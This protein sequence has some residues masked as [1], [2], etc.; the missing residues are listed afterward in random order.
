MQIPKKLLPSDGRFGS[1]PSKVPHEAMEALASSSVIGTSHRQEPVR[2]LVGSVREQLRALFSLPDDYEVVLGVGGST[3]FFDAATFGL[4]R[5]RSQHLAFGEFGAKFAKATSRAP[6]L[7]EP[8][9]LSSEP[10]THPDAQAES[11][12]D[13]YAWTHNETSTGVTAPVRRVEGADADSLVV[14]DG[15]SAA[16]GIPVDITQSDVYFFAPQKA[17][18]SDAG[19]WFA[20]MSPAALARVEEI[21]TS[22]RWIPAFLDLAAAVES[23]RKDQTYNT[24]PL[25]S[26]FWTDHQ[27][28]W[29]HDNGGL[30]WSVSRCED[31][32]SRLYGW[33]EQSSYATPFV[34]DPGK[35]SPTV[36]TIDL[37]GVEAS[38][39]SA[40]LRDN[41]IVDVDGYRGLGR[42]QLRI[43][44]FPAIEPDD[45]SALARCLDYV[46]EQLG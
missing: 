39:V 33:A 16:G 2:A 42:N 20:I 3:A 8:T 10:G 27:L 36:V 31:S 17:L 19:L 28:R 37:A 22:G 44:T 13:V 1:G 12:I 5:E 4:V 7:G 11:G 21:A 25:A 24:P 35:Q 45:V 38:A 23:S 15:T 14:I 41:G 26:L 43:A 29:I 30:P 40:A 46:V 9:V 18:A 34:A 6:F 32:S